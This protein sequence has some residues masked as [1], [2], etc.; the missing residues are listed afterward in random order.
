[1]A[2]YVPYHMHTQLSLLD[3]CAKYQ[4]YVNKAKE[5]G[6]KALAFSE[7]GNI[8]EYY[9]KK[10]AVEAAGMKYIHAVEAYVTE[11]KEPK[12]RDNYHVWLGAKNYEG[13]LELNELISKSFNRANVKIVGDE[14]NYYYN[15]RIT[16]KELYATSDNIIITSACLGGV[17][18]KA[19]REIRKQFAEFLAVNKHRC[20]LEI[21]H[22]NVFDQ[23]EYNKMIYRISQHY[24]IPMIAGTDTHALDAR[25]IKGRDILLKS[26]GKSYA[27]EEGWDL[28]FK[29]YDELVAAYELQNSLPREVYLEAIEN[30][31]VL[32]DMIESFTLDTCTKYPHIY[33]NS[34]E[35]FKKKINDAYKHHPYLRQRYTKA[36]VK[37][38]V[39]DELAVYEKTKSIDFMLLQIYLREWEKEQGIQCGYGRGSVSGSE[40]AYML[41]VTQMDSKRFDLNFFRFLNPDRVSNSDIDTDYSSKD[42]DKVKEFLLKD[43]LALDNIECS[44]IIT[45]NT[46]ALKG[47]IK[48]VCRALGYPLETAD[49]I[50][51]NVEQEEEKYRYLYPD[52]F[53]YVDILNGTVVSIGSHPSG[54]LVTD[55]DLSRQIG[56]CSISTSDYPVSMLNMKELDAL[57]YVKLDILGLDNLGVI[58]DTC[59]MVGI[60]RLNPDNVDLNDEAVWKSIRDDTTLVFQ[61]E[62]D[63]ASAYIK[64][65]MSDETLEV[66]KQVNPNFSYI[67]WFSFGNG[68]IRPGCASFRDNVADGEVL[69][70]GFKELDD[71][72]A[73]T[74]GR[75]TMQEDIMQFLVKFCGYNGAE[76]D[77]VRRGIAK[78]K[79]TEQFIDDIHARFLSYSHEIYGQPEEK[80]EEIFEPIK[81]GILDA[82]KYAFSWNH[83]DAYSVLGY[84]C[85]YLRYYYP[86]EFITCALNV[87]E[88]K[89]EKVLAITKYANAHGIKI[90]LPTYEHFGEEYTCDKE[91]NIIYKGLRGIKYMNDTITSE[92]NEVKTASN[93][94][95]DVLVNLQ[96]TRID[97][98]QLDILIKIGFFSG[99]GTINDLL[100]K[101]ALFNAWYGRKQIKK[102]EVKKL[103]INTDIILLHSIATEKMYKIT[104]SVGLLNDLLLITH[105][106][107]TTVCDRIGYQIEFLGYT[108]IIIP[109]TD[110]KNYYVTEIN[111][112]WLTLYQLKTGITTKIK[113]RANVLEN[114]PVQVGD[115]IKVIEIKEEPRYYKDQNGKWQRDY[116]NLENIL[117]RYVVLKK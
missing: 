22:H 117:R 26:K 4:D 62:S 80:L 116:D 58:N 82:T 29:T 70:T 47:A 71:F 20:F 39:N 31:N 41:G 5:C 60:E 17:L 52:I 66:A 13:F 54:V 115:V 44:E 3:S 43:H 7:H 34:L 107:K 25:Q 2:N 61:W 65:F 33:D 48:D 6:M 18:G 11:G 79:G 103:G 38:M 1:M 36:E 46:I 56:M 23:K 45:F 114:N 35:M 64:K 73:L 106:P 91:T 99:F 92:L 76:S 49:E 53:E 98:R 40:I 19:P 24:N 90:E 67:K 81:Q 101:V 63:A 96:N 108:D 86:L 42:R 55:V 69:T 8:F 59:K 9:H 110:E 95:L 75:I 10:L 111:G 37:K 12:E 104:D 27:D 16:F 112:S 77:S 88:D 68:L 105:T 93:S 50:S 30:T 74:M 87:F 94:L 97:S 109:K 57:F 32:A 113:S 85:G 72:L 84:I 78:K 83:S 51:K 100:N 21:Q 28:S 14:D 15:P 89:D 102:E